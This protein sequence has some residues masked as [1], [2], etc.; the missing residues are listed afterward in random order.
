MTLAIRIAWLVYGLY[1]LLLAVGSFSF[2]LWA[3]L[4]FWGAAVGVVAYFLARSVTGAY[5]AAALIA[6][7]PLVINVTSRSPVFGVVY[8]VLNAFLA[9]VMGW[10]A[11]VARRRADAARY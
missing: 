10:L 8:L 1:A 4:V 5:V 2:S 9:M 6:I 11:Y 7:G 3:A